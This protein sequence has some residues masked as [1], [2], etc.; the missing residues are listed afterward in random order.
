M[1]LSWSEFSAYL[2]LLFLLLEATCV[3]SVDLFL[4]FRSEMALIPHKVM[5]KIKSSKLKAFIKQIEGILKYSFVVIRINFP[6]ET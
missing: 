2:F 4:I 5:V 6:S 1:E 3:A